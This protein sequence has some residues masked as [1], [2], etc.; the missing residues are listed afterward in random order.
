M[1]STKAP[2]SQTSRLAVGRQTVK[3]AKPRKH[4]KGH[5]EIPMLQP[6]PFAVWRK[7]FE[8]ALVGDTPARTGFNK[9]A[10]YFA[11][12]REITIE[13]ENSTPATSQ[14]PVQTEVLEDLYARTCPPVPGRDPKR[15]KDLK[16]LV[17]DLEEL[18]DRLEA[19]LNRTQT[20]GAVRKDEAG[21][22]S[23]GLP[24]VAGAFSVDITPLIGAYQV[25]S[26]RSRVLAKILCS[27][28]DRQSDLVDQALNCWR[29]MTAK[30][31]L[32]HQEA[33]E[34]LFH[35]YA[36]HGY[37][38]ELLEP[39]IATQDD[40]D[41]N[42]SYSAEQKRTIR[43][44]A[45]SAREKLVNELTAMIYRTGKYERAVLKPIPFSVVLLDPTEK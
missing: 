17:G 6:L 21:V 45:D 34:L 26:D 29:D 38:D 18:A 14:A 32:T 9:L 7:E 40:D 12:L 23:I 36:A 41:D 16:K 44:R 15:L 39:F 3:R 43:K 2:N 31:H 28:Y 1:T 20:N 30:V 13:E 35:A 11:W 42:K 4:K 22:V 8:S 27:R 37:S 5:P 25:V 10:G 19:F 33:N 24:S